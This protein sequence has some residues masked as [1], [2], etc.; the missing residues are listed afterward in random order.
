MHPSAHQGVSSVGS[1]F[2]V[3]DSLLVH[4]GY[5]AL[6]QDDSTGRAGISRPAITAVHEMLGVVAHTDACCL[7]QHRQ[8][9]A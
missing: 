4:C 7:Q 9:Q 6:V 3:V 5:L 1:F 2:E 8:D